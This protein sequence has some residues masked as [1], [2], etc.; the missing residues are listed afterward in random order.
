[1]RRENG[2][3]NIT[4]RKD[5]RWV[6][7]YDTGLKNADGKRI[8][9]SVYGR[10][11]PEVKRKLREVR[12]TFKST[13]PI[14]VQKSIVKDFM[15]TWL[16]TVKKNDLKPTSYDRLETT[17]NK[18]VFPY[19]GNLQVHNVTSDHIQDMITKLRDEANR[20]YSTIKKAYDAVNGCWKWALNQKPPK[21]KYNPC[22]GVTIPKKK[23]FANSNQKVK[24]FT[25]EEA[26]RLISQALSCWGNGV[27]RYPLGSFVPLVI[28]T[29]LR[30]GELLALQWDR[31]IDL[32]AKQLTVHTGM[33]IIK[34]REKEKDDKSKPTYILVE[35]DTVKSDAGQDRTIDLNDAAI[36]ALED[37]MAVTGQY[38]NV[39]TT[40]NGTIVKPRQLDQMFRRIQAAAG[41]EEEHIY[42]V[43]SLR[44]TFA[45]L[46]IYNGIDIKIISKLMGHSDVSTTYNTYIH[47]IKEQQAKAVQSIPKL[48]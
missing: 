18:D 3:G 48:T 33:S 4:K 9:K 2:T 46:L 14:N 25:Q 6:G 13:E 45:T 29:G 15:T 24:F 11:E 16:T 17:L 28:N 34:D 38:T 23:T 20:G 26:Q 31:D 36:T 41:F 12:D 30:M 10:S 27:R 7:R 43:H 44:H 47:V 22:A 8:I 37:L 39:M 35:Q 21:V 1:M 40:S 42:G 32:E 19:I 5:G